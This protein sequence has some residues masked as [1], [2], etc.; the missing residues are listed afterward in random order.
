MC[1]SDNN[2]VFGDKTKIYILNRKGEKRINPTTNYPKA[3]NS[4]IFFQPAI[5][6]HDAK[7]ISSNPEGKIINIY[8]DGRATITS[9]KNVSEN[10]FFEYYDINADG[11]KDYIFLAKNILEVYSQDKKKLF[12]VNFE[13]EITKPPIIFE[14]STNNVKIGIVSQDENKIY[15]INNDGTIHKNFPIKASTAFSIGLL[16]KNNKFNI[17]TGFKNKI[18]Y[19]YLLD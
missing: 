1:L 15:L 17:I 18:L 5:N 16:N 3:N 12:S 11:K 10:H 4:K 14:F 19:N 6:E 2:L 9:I 13:K 7:F 8:L